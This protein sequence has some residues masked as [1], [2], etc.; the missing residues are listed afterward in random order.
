ML[1]SYC[2]MNIVDDLHARLHNQ[3]FC[4]LCEGCKFLNFKH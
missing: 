4:I 3:T 1:F 2:I